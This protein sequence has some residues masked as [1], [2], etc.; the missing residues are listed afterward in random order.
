MS[1][2]LALSVTLAFSLATLG[3][4]QTAGS[5]Q[6]MK[7][8]TENTGWA[9]TSKK[10]FWTTDNGAHWNDITPKLSHKTQTI[11]SVSFF[12][13]SAGSVLLRCAD[14]RDRLADEG[15]W[16]L[17]STSDAGQSWS[18]IHE[19]ISVPFSREQLE[20]RPFFSG[21]SWLQFVDSQ[22]G[23][24][25]LK[26]AT[27]SGPPSEGEMLRTLG[28]GKTWLPVKDLPT[29]GEFRFITPSDGW[30]I[31]GDQGGLF[32][33]H[34]AG[35]SWQ[36][37]FLPDPAGLGQHLPGYYRLPVFENRQQGV[38]TVQY[39]TGPSEGPNTQVLVAFTSE[40]G[41]KTWRQDGTL[42]SLPLINSTDVADRTLVA[43]HS[44][45]DQIP[46]AEGQCAIRRITLSIFR[47]RPDGTSSRAEANVPLPDGALNQVNFI[48]PE[49]GWAEILGRLFAT[50]DGGRT[51]L[52]LTPGGAPAEVQSVCVPTNASKSVRKHRPSDGWPGL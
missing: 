34:D 12:D 45:L 18:V 6:S 23:W 29:S 17:A 44:K 41:G 14:D 7:L 4:A 42:S 1:K 51:W 25:I 16:E 26:I 20:D 38:V 43:A 15:C 30:I 11:S 9:A 24:E 8:L 36:K 39:T 40:D 46:Q 49:L 50:Q 48:S 13:T 19:K 31:G 27:G 10:L 3:R 32:V 35:D 33:T 28:G 21:Q 22:H 5:I 2:N 37:F 47:L 52:E